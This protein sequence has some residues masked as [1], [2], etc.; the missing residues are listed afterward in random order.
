M[1]EKK[2]LLTESE[3]LNS[4]RYPFVH[5]SEWLEAHEYHER[6][7]KNASGYDDVFKCSECCCEVEI[8]GECGNEYGELFH[9][10]YMPA[11][12]P[13]CGAKVVMDENGE[14]QSD[15]GAHA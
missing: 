11:Y 8:I 2:Y 5:S 4:P 9:V 7:C 14:G 6:T 13:N 1:S 15:Q 3:L 12:C 10:P